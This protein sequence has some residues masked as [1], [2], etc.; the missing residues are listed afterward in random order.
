MKLASFNVENLFERAR[1]LALDEPDAKPILER[2]AELN[3]LLAKASYSAADKA[4]I[5]ELLVAL[6]LQASDDGG[7]YALLRENRGHLVT[8]R[9]TGQLDVTANGR[10][11][12]VGWVEL[13]RAPVNA[14]STRHTAMVVKDIGADI[15]GVVEVES[16]PTLKNF[17]EIMLPAAGASAYAHAM[18]IDGND[19]RGIDVGLLVADG[20][21][22]TSMRSHVD[23]T[24]PKGVVFSRDCPEYVVEGSN[25][26]RIVVL[27]NHLK[28]KGYGKQNENDARRRRQAT[29]VAQ[30]YRGL[31][32]AGEQNVVVVGDF[33]DIPTSK[34]LAPLLKKTDLQDITTSPKF[35]PDGRPGTYANGAASQKI[36]YLLLSPALFGLVKKGG[37]YRKG[38]WGGKNGTLFPHYPT[39]TQPAEAASDHAAIWAEI[40][41]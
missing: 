36:D 22:I 28:S 18:L 15:L 1:A 3:A 41:L 33:N 11:D 2:Q 20:W 23:D 12:W 6:G 40:D 37:I 17:S 25:G 16:R 7:T 8:R 13:K 4:R 21:A 29:R 24:D 32:A 31:R 14:L 35:K 5:T 39:I 30:I 26:V 10:D 34:P 19:E 38:V 27:V 9:V